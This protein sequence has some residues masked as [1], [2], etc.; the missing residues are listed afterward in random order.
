VIGDQVQGY[1]AVMS[2]I[3]LLWL[4]QVEVQVMK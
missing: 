4:L 3:R 2:V 1:Q